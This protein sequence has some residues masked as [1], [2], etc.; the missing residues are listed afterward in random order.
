MM[1]YMDSGLKNSPQTHYREAIE[2]NRYLAD[3]PEL[4]TKGKITLNRK[5]T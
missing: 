2:M 4:I 1:V 5:K 3:L